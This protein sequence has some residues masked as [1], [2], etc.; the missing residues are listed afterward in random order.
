MQSTEPMQISESIGKRVDPTYS[1]VLQLRLKELLN[2]QNDRYIYI[3]L[4]AK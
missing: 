3:H 2:N 1:K 4:Y